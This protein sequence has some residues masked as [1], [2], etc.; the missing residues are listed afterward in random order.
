MGSIEVYD[1]VQQKW[2]PYRP[3]PERMFQHFKDIRDGYAK[4]D[5][6]GRYIIGE[7]KSVRMLERKLKETEQKLKEAEEKLKDGLEVQ[8]V[9]PVA[10]AN[11][12][13]RSEVSRLQRADPS[14]RKKRKSD[15]NWDQLK[16]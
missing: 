4:P 15:L 6:R 9:S 14:V 5:H 2:V 10:Q 16:F 12:I 7:G 11:D 8:W 13:A 1:H 3:D